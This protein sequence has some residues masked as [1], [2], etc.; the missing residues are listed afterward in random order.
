MSIRDRLTKQSTPSTM[1]TGRPVLGQQRRS[2]VVDTSAMQEMKDKLHLMLIEKINSITDWQKIN[3][4]EQN[5]FIKQFI[6]RRLE[7]DFSTTPLSNSE[8][9]QIV[10]EIRQEVKGFGPLDPLLCDPSVS[11]ILVNG[12]NQVYVEVSG[13]LKKTNVHFKDNAHLMNI[14]ERIVSKVGRRID[15]K[16]PMVDA[17]LPDGS[18]V[19]AVIPP[20]AIDG[21]SLSIRRF[22][23]DAATI[24]NLL[25]WGSMTVGMAETLKAAVKAHLNIVI[26]GGTGAGKTTLLNSLSS[27]IPEDER[28]VTIEDSAEL[29]LQ[30][31]HVVRLE[32]RPANIEGTGAITA[33]DLLINSL[34]MRPDRVVIGECRGAEAFDMLQAMNTGHDGSLTTLHANTPRDAC[35]R[36][37]TMCMYTGIDL[38]EKTIRQQISSAVHLIIQ[39]SRLTDGSRRVTYISEITGMEGSIITIQDIFKWEQYG[40]DENGRVIGCHVSTGVRPKFGDKCKAKGIKLPLEIFDANAPAVYLC[41]N[42]PNEKMGAK[43]KGNSPAEDSDSLD[44]IIRQRKASRFK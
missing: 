32:T 34:R 12:P 38:P 13:K 39:A 41:K 23:A 40:L 37:E 43:A 9:D 5:S 30:Q 33:R 20:L 35:A 28:I 22:K 8:K 31:E 18:R 24:Q 19:N 2:S 6:E 4:T 26:S 3:D 44:D 10:Q 29:S 15:E 17:R 42:P 11:D 14:I 27:Q 7:Q 1:P 21:A 36:L 16:S 25:T